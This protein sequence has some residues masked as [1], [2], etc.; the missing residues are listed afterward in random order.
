MHI[1]VAFGLI[2]FSVQA[3]IADSNTLSVHKVFSNSGNIYYSSEDDI[4]TQLTHTGKDNSPVL[5]S[6]KKLIAFIRKGEESIPK[7]C[8]GF[9]SADRRYG[10]QIWIYN[11]D[12]HKERS[13]VESN[14]SCDEPEK[15]L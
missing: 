14:F 2:L 11:L 9:V 5:S 8:D 10:D 7:S 13:L 12:M 1:M 15:K 6:N 3:A 4:N